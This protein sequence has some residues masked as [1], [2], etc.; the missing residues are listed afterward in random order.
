MCAY[1][2]SLT[3]E[4]VVEKQIADILGTET[5]FII[6]IGLELIGA[7]T[8]LV[9]C[10][11]LLCFHTYFLVSESIAEAAIVFLLLLTIFVV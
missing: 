6:L 2:L 8:M 1:L 9:P 11:T 3:N 7:F 4:E 10:T 5:L